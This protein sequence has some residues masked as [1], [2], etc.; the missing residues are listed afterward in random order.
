MAVNV[1]V[2]RGLASRHAGR[3]PLSHLEEPVWLVQR[4]LAARLA[5][6]WP[7]KAARAPYSGPFAIAQVG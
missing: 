6:T 7:P 5:G 4:H 2:Q 1:G 3:G